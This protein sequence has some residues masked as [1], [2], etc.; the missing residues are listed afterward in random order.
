MDSTELLRTMWT[1]WFLGFFGPN[2][3][4]SDTPSFGLNRSS[5]MVIRPVRGRSIHWIGQ[6]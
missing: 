3:G 6:N 2:R 1:T 5:P 4:C